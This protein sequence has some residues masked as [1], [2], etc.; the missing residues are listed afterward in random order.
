M[1]TTTRQTLHS[2]RQ[3]WSIPPTDLHLIPP[4]FLAG[5]PP[6]HLSPTLLAAIHRLS[7][8]TLGQR[9]RA[10]NLLNTYF[11]ARMRERGSAAGQHDG[12]VLEVGDV[13]KA[14]GS[15]KK[16]SCV[17]VMVEQQGRID[18]VYTLDCVGNGGQGESVRDSIE[19]SREAQAQAQAQGSLMQKR[20]VELA[21]IVTA[22]SCAPVMT[23]AG[24]EGEMAVLSS[25]TPLFRRLQNEF[26][27]AGAG[28]DAGGC[29]DGWERGDGQQQGFEGSEGETNVSAAQRAMHEFNARRLEMQG[30][31]REYED[32]VWRFEEARWRVENEG[33]EK[34]SLN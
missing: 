12:G 27:G 22:Q 6:S 3:N 28:A 30:K 25:F 20:R 33:D 11:Q 4:S 7:T 9:D 15:A 31:K 1:A 18:S 21:P 14:C 19:E 17:G 2:I 8:L 13:E 29:L 26:A 23:V 32:A 34:M 16:M 24:G 10:Y 5:L